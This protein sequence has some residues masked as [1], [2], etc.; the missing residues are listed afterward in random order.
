VSKPSR[1]S[2]LP[3]LRCFIDCTEIFIET[4]K[5]PDVQNATWS[6]YKHHNTAKFLIGVAP[7]SAITFVS[8]MYG[9]RTSD[10]EITIDSGFLDKCEPFDMIQADKGF[11]IREECHARLLTLHVPPGL[12]GQVQMT[13]VAVAKTKQIA[14]LRILIEQVIRRLKT[15][16]ILSSQVS[17]TLLPCLSRIVNVCA[18]LCNYKI[19]PIYND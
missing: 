12:R 19:K 10:K 15:Y 1:F 6:N 2:K 4:P 9:G 8:S 13:S 7:N 16:R 11:N 14:N 5:D 18:A 17:I 3:D